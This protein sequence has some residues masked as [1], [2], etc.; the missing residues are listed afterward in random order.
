[1]IWSQVS[2]GSI[3]QERSP[4]ISWAGGDEQVSVGPN[5]G[6]SRMQHLS[7]SWSASST[8]APTK[9]S[10]A[11]GQIAPAQLPPNP[12]VPYTTQPN[13]CVDDSVNYRSALIREGSH[14][15]DQAGKKQA[16]APPR[17]D[18]RMIGDWASVSTLARFGRT[19]SASRRLSPLR[20]FSL[21]RQLQGANCNSGYLRTARW[22]L[23]RFGSARPGTRNTSLRKCPPPTQHSPDYTDRTGFR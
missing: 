1:V 15:W 7:W 6:Y 13:G 10:I 2:V 16:E 9:C 17:K 21:L 5:R 4:S 22:L 11:T 12:K 14:R 8:S 23:P 3:V 19:T 20:A 18:G